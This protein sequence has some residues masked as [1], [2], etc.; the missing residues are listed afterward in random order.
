MEER[1]LA[2]EEVKL[3]TVEERVTAASYPRTLY[4]F[5]DDG[6][7]RA[8]D[9]VEQTAHVVPSFENVLL[10]RPG[11]KQLYSSVDNEGQVR[12]EAKISSQFTPTLPP[13]PEKYGEDARVS[14][15]QISPRI[16]TTEDQMKSDIGTVGSNA[17]ASARSPNGEGV[18][19]QDTEM[20]GKRSGSWA[21]TA[22]EQRGSSGGAIFPDARMPSQQTFMLA[23]K[24]G[25]VGQGLGW[26]ES[27]TFLNALAG[28]DQLL[29]DSESDNGD[30]HLEA[31]TFS[32][33]QVHARWKW[34]FASVLLGSECRFHQKHRLCGGT[35]HGKRNYNFPQTATISLLPLAVISYS[36]LG[37]SYS[38]PSPTTL[39][40]PLFCR[41]FPDAAPVSAE[42]ARR[43]NAARR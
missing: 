31:S 30:V 41:G 38:R 11:D 35:N 25:K 42:Q 27:L 2:E 22:H 6:G 15:G 43:G 19:V 3:S 21:L 39:L 34:S 9:A 7:R 23:P 40:P 28:G 17:R 36:V 14:D 1:A 4:P 26:D 29:S 37:V 13:A 10:S 18:Q 16:Q 24:D 5:V 32:P 8:Q 12:S 20:A 33:S